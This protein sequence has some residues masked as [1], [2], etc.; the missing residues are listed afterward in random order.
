LTKP[1]LYGI[2][3]DEILFVNLEGVDSPIGA[4]D[5]IGGA[6]RM[7]LLIVIAQDEDA[8]LL[9]QRL[10]AV[11]LRA[12]K[13]DTVGGFLAVEDVFDAI[14]ATCHTR[15]RFVN[16]LMSTADGLSLTVPGPI[17]PMEVEIGG[18]IVFSLPVKRHVLTH[19]GGPQPVASRDGDAVETK[20]F[21]APGADEIAGA[22]A[23]SLVLSI[24][25]YEDADKVVGGLLAGGHRVTRINTAGVF[26]RRR[27]V[28]LLVGVRQ[29]KVDEV[30]TIIQTNCRRREGATPASEGMPSYSA[31]TFV[32][33][34]ARLDR[35]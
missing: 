17:L 30:L 16:P 21:A 22:N 25:R 26:L 32:L 12:T 5:L 35:I 13:I 4:S 11:N 9:S 34:V 8:D 27:N 2:K 6:W 19:G 14:R 15:R 18:A 20:E 24:V 10:G 28:T 29:D 23:M 3:A 7:Q 1:Q 33:D 31:T